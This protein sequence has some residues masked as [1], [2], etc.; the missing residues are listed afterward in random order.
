MLFMLFV[1]FMRTGHSINAKEYVSN[2][3]FVYHFDE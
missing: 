3:H 1:L 2:P